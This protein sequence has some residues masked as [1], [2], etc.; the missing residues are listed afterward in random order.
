[1]TTE[2]IPSILL[3]VK[4]NLGIASEY[5]HFDADIISHINSS[6]AIL[7]QEGVGPQDKAA[8]IEDDAY[9]WEMLTK[10]DTSLNFVQSS[11]FLRVKM[12]N[13]NSRLLM[14]PENVICCSDNTHKAIHYGDANLLDRSPYFVERKPNDTIPW[15]K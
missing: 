7:F 8:Q 9:T 3:S 1:M 6:L 5:T 2:Y 13:E 10:D 12:L 14:A 15:R 4:K 11:V